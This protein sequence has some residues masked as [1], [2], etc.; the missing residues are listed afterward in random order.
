MFMEQEQ[1][2]EQ[3]ISMAKACRDPLTV[4]FLIYASV[5]NVIALYL[6]PCVNCSLMHVSF[7]PC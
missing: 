1:S 6:L 2:G 5:N 3:W 7:I 4:R